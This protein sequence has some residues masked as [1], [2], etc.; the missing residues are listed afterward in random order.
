MSIMGVHT[1]AGQ[2]G[3]ITTIVIADIAKSIY[4]TAR[5]ARLVAMQYLETIESSM[6]IS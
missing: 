3:C 5:E 6:L 1:E 4:S 2:A